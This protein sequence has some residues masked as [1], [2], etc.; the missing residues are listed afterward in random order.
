MCIRDRYGYG[1]IDDLKNGVASLMQFRG[2][3]SIQQLVGIAGPDIVLPFEEITE[4]K[5]IP[6]VKVELCS[7]CGNC[8]SCHAQA[9]HLDDDKYPV[10]DPE[11]CI[12][13][14]FCSQICFTGALKMIVRNK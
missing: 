8:T 12:G 3:G 7:G 14:S 9:V 13:C 4:E 10:F 1:I 11:R 6:A 5:K 2:I